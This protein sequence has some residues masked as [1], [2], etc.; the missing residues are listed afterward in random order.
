VNTHR[1]APAQLWGRNSDE[2]PDQ[3]LKPLSS[4]IS[5]N[6]ATSTITRNF[7]SLYCSTNLSTK[8]SRK[9]EGRC[10]VQWRRR[11]REIVGTYTIISHR[12]PG[13]CCLAS[14]PN[15]V[16]LGPGLPGV[17]R[18]SYLIRVRENILMLMLRIPRFNDGT[19]ANPARVSMAIASVISKK[20]DIGRQSRSSH[21]SSPMWL[22]EPCVD[23]R[24]LAPMQPIPFVG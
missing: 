5:P 8:V 14:E 17:Q 21:S 13:K 11:G 19:T 2:I 24:S 3:I 23:V 16:R 10:S 1:G 9:M 7:F 15:E 12:P 22:R 4:E 20:P 6:E 18:L